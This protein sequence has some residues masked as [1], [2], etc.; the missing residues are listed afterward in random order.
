[1]R[2]PVTLPDVCCCQ[3]LVQEHTQQYVPIVGELVLSGLVYGSG[4][5][6]K[7]SCRWAAP[8]PP[9]ASL[10]HAPE[11]RAAKT[12]AKKASR[13]QRERTRDLN[14]LPSVPESSPASLPEL[15]PASPVASGSDRLR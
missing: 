10:P 13:H 11:K 3:R 14:Q 6:R 5:G 15:S 9:A 1:M 7:R 4:E 2:E 8:S 12:P